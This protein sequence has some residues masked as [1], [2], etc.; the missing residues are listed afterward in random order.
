MKRNTRISPLKMRQAQFHRAARHM[1]HIKRGLIDYFL[2]PN[3]TI[4]M[5]FP[6]EMDDG[7]VRVFRG[8]RTLHSSILGPGKGGIRYHPKV[9]M[10]E[11]E[12]LATLM[13][14]KCALIGVPFGGAKGG[15]TCDVKTLSSGELRRMTRRYVAELG[16]NIGPYT[17]VPAPDLYTNAQ[18]M[19]WV[20]DTYQAMHGGENNLPVVT[21]KPLDLGGAP[22]REE[23]T[24]RGTFAALERAL[25]LDPLPGG[26]RLDG[27]S[28]V[29]QGYGEVGRTAARLC[30]EAGARVI[31]ISDSGG[32]VIA[33]AAG[34]LDLDI[35][36]RH[37][38]SAGSVVGCPDTTTISNDELLA[39]ECDVL[40]PAALGEQIHAGNAEAVRAQLIV[41][42]ANAP[43][44]PQADRMLQDRGVRVL[45][46]IL[47]N[48]GGVVVSYFEWVQNLRNERWSLEETNL[49][50]DER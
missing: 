41:E 36:S 1:G 34:G 3:R 33:T 27:A 17:D 5:T 16:D 47:V 23:A 9:T 24:G 43:V 40:V 35:V 44:T 30:R 22:G 25:E 10:R 14:W 6:I 21:G 19:A 50:L 11:V 2:R 38:D 42:A 39:L 37:K 48:S 26:R 20:Y 28:V 18:T 15:I 4:A 49:K 46:D 12:S 29:V 32:G 45:P 7:S 13:T 31:A 8:Y